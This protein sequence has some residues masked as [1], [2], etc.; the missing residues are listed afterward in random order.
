MSINN[1]YSESRRKKLHST[2]RKSQK[3]DR[4]ETWHLRQ[5]REGKFAPRLFE[6]SITRE[7]KIVRTCGL[8]SRS[9]KGFPENIYFF[10][11]NKN[12]TPNPCL[13]WDEITH[14]FLPRQIFYLPRQTFSENRL[15]LRYLRWQ[16]PVLEMSRDACS[17]RR[18]HTEWL[19]YAV[20]NSLNRLH[21]D[22]ILILC[23]L[24]TCMQV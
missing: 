16:V 4:S 19:K 6:M 11:Q 20:W 24:G 13:S 15:F 21:I 14:L 22:T 8:H 2:S 12:F 5:A 1:C 23:L 9:K 7:Q 10:S 3:V 18:T 17:R